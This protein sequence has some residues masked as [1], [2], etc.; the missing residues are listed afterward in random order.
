MMRCTP[1]RT[2]KMCTV[3]NTLRMTSAGI[4]PG[5]TKV[6]TM[7]LHD[8]MCPGMVIDQDGGEWACKYSHDNLHCEDCDGIFCEH[9]FNEQQDKCCECLGEIIGKEDY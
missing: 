8:R 2:V 3:M 6:I 4:A 7:G 5:E 9:H 1:V